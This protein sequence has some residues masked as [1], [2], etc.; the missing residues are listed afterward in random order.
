MTPARPFAHLPGVRYPAEPK[1]AK[2]AAPALPPGCP[3]YVATKAQLAPWVQAAGLWGRI[4]SRS[5]LDRWKRWGL[6]V[7][8]KGATGVDLIDV[9]ATLAMLTP[10]N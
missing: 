10:K 4:P 3:R 7:T 6:I 2:P 9:P 1:P 8:K 5:T